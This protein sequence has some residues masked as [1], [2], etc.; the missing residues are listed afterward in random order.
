MI[1]YVVVAGGCGLRWVGVGN[2]GR[3]ERQRGAG[4]VAAHTRR[5]VDLAGPLGGAWARPGPHTPL[6]QCSTW[7]QA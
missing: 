6:A 7:P 2:I 3:H 1:K 4:V 5:A